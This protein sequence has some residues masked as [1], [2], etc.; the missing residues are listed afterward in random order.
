MST[1]G[2][3]RAGRLLTAAL[4]VA[5][6]GGVLMRVPLLGEGK[7]N[8]DEAIVGLMGMEI[9]KG[10]HFAFYW[11]QTYMGSLEAYTAALLFRLLGVSPWSL[12]LAP[13]LWFLAAALFHYLFFR[14]AWGRG[15]A[16]AAVVFLF[17]SPSVFTLW[18][19]AARGGYMEAL[20]LGG[21]AMWLSAVIRQRREP[22]WGLYLALGLVSGLGFW[23]HYFFVYYLLP[24]ALVV[25][26][27]A[28]RGRG[29]WKALGALTAG[30]L[31]GASPALAY[32]LRHGF[33]SA[34][35]VKLAAKTDF[36]A[37]LFNLRVRQ[38]PTLLGANKPTADH[39]LWPP[40]SR[41]FLLLWAALAAWFPVAA[42]RRG[43]RAGAAPAGV[44]LL[45]GL[46]ILVALGFFLG[47]G[48]GAFNT[49]RYLLPAY[50]LLAL[51]LAA[52]LADL[53]AVR[54]WA[55]V[56]AGAFVLV[57]NLFGTWHYATRT[58]LPESR[59]FMARMR[60][61]ADFCRERGV[62][63]AWAGH[64]QCY[65]LTFLSRQELVVGD[66]ERERYRPFQELVA[67]SPSPALISEAYRREISATLSAIRLEFE[68]GKIGPY[69]VFAHP[70]FPE[71][72]GPG[73]L[74]ETPFEASGGRFEPL[75]G[76]GFVSDGPQKK[77]MTFTLRPAGPRQV[78]GVILSPG[79]NRSA[80]PRSFM[81][82]TSADGVTWEAAA[83]ASRY[84][85][86]IHYRDRLR[87]ERGGEVSVYFRPRPASLVRVVLDRREEEK[88]LALARAWLSVD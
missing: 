49:Q 62:K 31:L 71:G 5:V 69:S 60:Q 7:L 88:P 33:A 80:Y 81:V 46:V 15:T 13:F 37:N 83:E 27:P 22:G 20:A 36:G 73:R 28:L 50:P 64:W 9:N 86:G 48:Y 78:G 19:L 76:G 10:H 53:A 2:G 65:V 3:R 11:G 72:V 8:S 82:E 29:R 38:L 12:K 54:R 85:G 23:T 51:V 68:L 4:V 41:A 58:Y 42:W 6:L 75:A 18:T 21:A 26:L 35:V 77:G 47:T 30:F 1:G 59:E 17:L 84:V 39:P 66:I 57:V 45:P 52:G 67:A 56:L 24:V 79:G 87:W 40:L 44:R 55:A 43:R 63:T 70:R 32:N 61:I 16:A 14:R 74:E 25:V 34:G